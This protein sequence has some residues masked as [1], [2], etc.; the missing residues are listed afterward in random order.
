M[1]RNDKIALRG[2]LWMTVGGVNLGGPGRI[3]LLARIAE[4]G[5]ITQ[6]A[7][8]MKMSYKAAWDAIDHMNNLA[9]QPLVER[10]VGGKGGGAT[11]LTARGE[12]LV[13][14]FR[15]IE[16]AHRRFVD[17]L[18]DEIEMA[19]V[20]GARRSARN[21]LTGTLSA[22]A[23][24]RRE[25]RGGHRPARRRRHRGDHHQRKREESGLAV[26]GTATAVQGLQ[27]HHRRGG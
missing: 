7:K 25:Y 16:Q 5:S 6:A 12:R 14:S 24:R 8:A 20:G 9:R 18:S 13:A 17:Q 19:I 10:M 11:R 26:G 3:E 23:G 22:R 1:A 27:R 15:M 21:R 2:Q 4:L